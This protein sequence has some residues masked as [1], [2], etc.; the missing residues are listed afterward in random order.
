M[1]T[2][3]ESFNTETASSRGNGGTI[4]QMSKAVSPDLEQLTRDFRA[5]VA[6]CET[7]LKNATT[8]STAGASVARAQLSDRMASAKVKLDA[9]RMNAGDRAARTRA[10]TEEY[11]RREPMKAMGYALA[12]GAILGLL[13]AR[14]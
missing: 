6:D 1:E 12:A 5:F 2:S 4:T 3:A 10:T 8:L 7:L 11:V 13:M 14:R 9:M